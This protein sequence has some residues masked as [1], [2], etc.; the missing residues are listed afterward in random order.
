MAQDFL[1]SIFISLLLLHL[2]NLN[3]DRCRV[4]N[5][6]DVDDLS[7]LL[8]LLSLV[9]VVLPVLLIGDEVVELDDRE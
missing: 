1:A 6:D 3:I 7:L 8:V 5:V 4:N 2:R 9:D